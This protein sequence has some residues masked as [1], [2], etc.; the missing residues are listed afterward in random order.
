VNP[1]IPVDKWNI[2]FPRQ[3][4]PWPTP[5]LRRISINSFGVGGT[6]AHTI[7]DDAFM[8]LSTRGLQ[9]PHNTTSERSTAEDT[10]PNEEPLVQHESTTKSQCVENGTAKSKDNGTKDGFSTTAQSSIPLLFPITSFDEGGVRRNAARLATYLKTISTP[11][12]HFESQYLHDLAYT[13]T[14]RRSV[15]P[16]RS[17][18]I[19][20]S[21]LG[22]LQNLSNDH[23]VPKA[24]RAKT[25]PKIGFVF[26]GQ[27]AQWYAMGRELMVYPV[28]KGSIEAASAYM[29]TLGA[30]WNL[31]EELQK[32]KEDTRVNQPFLA[33]PSCVALQVALVELL[34]SWRI[35]PERVVGHSS[36]EIAAAFAAAKLGREAAWKAGYFRGY[37]S[38]KSIGKGGAMIAVGLSVED[39]EVYMKTIHAELPGEVSQTYNLTRSQRD[40]ITNLV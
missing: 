36:G 5:G 31:T 23:G 10:K 34:A 6:N 26:T 30:E 19:S 39:T 2:Q 11:D 27:G 14:S 28:F 37:V 24:V 40:H 12:G 29:M 4:V 7:L 25:T 21:V 15:F 18:T 16:W 33:H 9:A 1:K 38:A 35:L 8:Y 3:N 20:N 17:Y 32:S 13:L 22:L